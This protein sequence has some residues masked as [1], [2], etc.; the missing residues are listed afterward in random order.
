[1]RALQGRGADR[2][3]RSA[4]PLPASAVPVEEAMTERK[5]YCFHCEV[6]R[7]LEIHLQEGAIDLEE[8][9]LKVAQV[10]GEIIAK[11]P[12][13]YTAI[14]DARRMVVF[15]ARQKIETKT[16]GKTRH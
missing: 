10:L 14:E 5:P 13:Y 2:Q 6:T 3:D 11:R 1:M 8:A 7:I 12:D 9:L 16:E 4:E 15:S